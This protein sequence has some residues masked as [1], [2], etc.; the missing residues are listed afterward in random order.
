MSFSSQYRSQLERKR[1]QRVDAEKKAS[2]YRKKEADKRLAATKARLAAARTNS[3]STMATRLREAE[4]HED[5][6]NK[7]GQEA[8]R[9]QG[10]AASYAKE[11]AGLQVKLM[12]AEQSE[13]AADDRRRERDRQAAE[14][15]ATAM[16]ARVSDRLAATEARVNVA[17]R[18]LRA[19]RPERLRVLML[20]ASA[21]GDLRVGREQKRIRAA[22]ESALHRDLVELD[23]R[24][25]ARAG[26]SL[27][28]RR[29]VNR[30]LTFAD[31]DGVQRRTRVS[32]GPEVSRAGGLAMRN[33]HET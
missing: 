9:W 8:A 11:E 31:R 5:E 26:Q 1:T 3:A 10:E 25:S 15:A 23:V 2:E 7:A 20:A 13:V 6:A 27:T 21:A 18:E 16:Q 28:R 17:L 12:K 14:R 30:R 29:S 22:V 4:R 19:P 32:P 24:P 33:D